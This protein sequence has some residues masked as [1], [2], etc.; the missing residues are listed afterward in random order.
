MVNN[1]NVYIYKHFDYQEYWI[2]LQKI[3]IND[4]R[5]DEYCFER[6]TNNCRLRLKAALSTFNEKI[7]N[8][9]Y[10]R[11]GV[12]VFSTLFQSDAEMQLLELFLNWVSQN[13][14]KC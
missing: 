3:Q 1:Q 11:L 10:L 14:L 5:V 4:E 9:P 8:D 12:P 13:Y 6:S 2:K 7:S